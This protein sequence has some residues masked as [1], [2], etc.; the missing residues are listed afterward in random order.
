MAGGT[1]GF[2]NRQLSALADLGIDRQDP[3]HGC[4]LLPE[5]FPNSEC[6]IDK[7][8]VAKDPEAAFY[9]MPYPRNKNDKAAYNKRLAAVCA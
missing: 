7:K 1:D 2:R 6:H 5:T 8:A 3:A 4:N 9:V